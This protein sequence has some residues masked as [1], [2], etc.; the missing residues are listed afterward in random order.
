MRQ[1][2]AEWESFYVITGS[3]G[4]A[5][6]GIMFVV[7]ALAAERVGNRNPETMSTFSTPTT[8]HFGV[9]LLIASLM[10]MPHDGTAWLEGSLALCTLGGFVYIILGVRG[11]HRV[12]AYRPA[13]E[14]WWWYAI[15]PVAAYVLLLVATIL[16]GT[17]PQLALYLI[18]AVVIFLLFIGIHNAWDIALFVATY[19]H[20]QRQQGAVP[21]VPP[22]TPPVA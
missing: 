3:S 18:G 17:S 14:D 6:T 11:M 5:L 4:A 13:R 1:L 9:V 10:T 2:L 7:I 19:G 8:T 21:P 12:Q 20:E 22:P 15:L 16:L